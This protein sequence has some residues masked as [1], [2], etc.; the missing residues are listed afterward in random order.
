MRVQPSMQGMVGILHRGRAT[1]IDLLKRHETVGERRH[2]K[3]GARRDQQ[4]IKRVLPLFILASH[5]MEFLRSTHFERIHD[6][7]KPPRLRLRQPY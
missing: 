4:R 7:S 5:Q 6:Y 2:T 3:D 1:G